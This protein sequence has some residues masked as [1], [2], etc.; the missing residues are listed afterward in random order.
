MDKDVPHG[1][2]ATVAISRCKQ[3]LTNLAAIGF[4]LGKEGV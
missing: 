3:I 4:F 2:V 1:A